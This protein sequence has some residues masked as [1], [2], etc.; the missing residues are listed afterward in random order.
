MA[1]PCAETI[2]I[3][4]ELLASF[5]SRSDVGSLRVT[6][7]SKLTDLST[8]SIHRRQATNSGAERH[9]STTIE[10]VGAEV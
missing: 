10:T 6:M 5:E 8:C 4:S 1:F 2:R 9:P 7:T 3:S